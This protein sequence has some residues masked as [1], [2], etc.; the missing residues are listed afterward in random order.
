[1]HADNKIKAKFI[2]RINQKHVTAAAVIVSGEEAG[3]REK[4]NGSDSRE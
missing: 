2:T 4:E 3:R 1:V